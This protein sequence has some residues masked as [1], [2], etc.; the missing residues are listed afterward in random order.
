MNR[1]SAAILLVLAAGLAGC[2]RTEPSPAAVAKACEQIQTKLDAADEAFVNRV[3]EIRSE[4]ILLVDYDRKMIDALSA[5]RN[6]VRV[7][8]D[9]ENSDGIACTGK[10]LAEVKLSENPRLNRVNSYLADFQQALKSDRPDV[11]VP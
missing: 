11:Y 9:Q 10:P 1:S 5:Y 2:S 3:R 4:H 6:Q 8:L 7:L